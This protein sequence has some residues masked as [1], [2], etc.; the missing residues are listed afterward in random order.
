MSNVQMPN[1]I[2]KPKDQSAPKEHPAQAEIRKAAVEIDEGRWI[3]DPH[4]D[5][6]AIDDLGIQAAIESL[7]DSWS[8]IS[9]V[10]YELHLSPEES[11]REMRLPKAVETTLYRVL[12]ETLT[13][14]VRHAEAH[15]VGVILNIS[16]EVATMIVEDDGRGFDAHGP[17]IE[18]TPARRLGL[19]G[20][21]E[22]LAL[23]GGTLEIESSPGQ[24]ATLFIRIPI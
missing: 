7:L 6:T 13:N 12:Q 17:D 20:I 23:V 14:V 18:R 2:I 11:P 9:L 8:E 16:E 4:S 21:R 22:R 10:K 24:G 5:E 19:L 15:K 1:V 3:P